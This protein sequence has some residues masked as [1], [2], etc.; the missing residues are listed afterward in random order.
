[1]SSGVSRGSPRERRSTTDTTRS[2]DLHAPRKV[3]TLAAT[4]V[5]VS[6]GSVCVLTSCPIEGKSIDVVEVWRGAARRARRPGGG[7]G[8]VVGSSAGVAGRLVGPGRVVVAWRARQSGRA[9]ADRPHPVRRGARVNS[10]HPSAPSGRVEGRGAR[11]RSSPHATGAPGAPG[12]MRHGRAG[13]GRAARPKL[14]PCGGARAQ[15]RQDLADHVPALVLSWMNAR[16]ATRELARVAGRVRSP[17]KARAARA[18]GAK[19]GRRRESSL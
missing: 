17:A 4:R 7:P 8:A 5:S 9:R 19:G 16:Q 12:A 2:S 11:G 18:N 10:Q 1:M 3:R 14:R 15:V 13:R 6:G